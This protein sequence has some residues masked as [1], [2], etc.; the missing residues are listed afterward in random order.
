[1]RAQCSCNN[2]HG[3]LSRARLDR[4]CVVWDMHAGEKEH[5]GRVLGERARAGL[6]VR[7]ERV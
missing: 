1:M 7:D 5:M 2:A 4:M 3:K 6:A